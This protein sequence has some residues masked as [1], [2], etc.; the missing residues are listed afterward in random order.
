MP[1][2]W[3]SPVPFDPQVQRLLADWLVHVKG[4]R[5]PS[6]DD[7]DTEAD[8]MQFEDEDFEVFTAF[9]VEKLGIER[10]DDYD[11]TLSN[12]IGFSAWT[13]TM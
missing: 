9:A 4:R 2:D 5:D 8:P 12:A 13:S 6:R 7:A 10:S 1:L 3:D 11:E